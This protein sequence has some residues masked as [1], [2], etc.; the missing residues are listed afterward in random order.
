MTGL[1]RE[2]EAFSK[3]LKELP[4]SGVKEPKGCSVRDVKG[5]APH[6]RSKGGLEHGQGI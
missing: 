2:C 5:N 3:Q 6:S 4:F 1:A